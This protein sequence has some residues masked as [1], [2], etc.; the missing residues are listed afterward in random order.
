MLLVVFFTAST[1]ASCT[2]GS[3]S[4]GSDDQT[5]EAAES[6]EEETASDEHPSGDGDE[7]PSGDEA[8]ADSTA[9]DDSS[10]AEEVSE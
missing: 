4:E 8:E 7:H 3:Q 1:I 9:T 10:S 6:A 5:E 2:G